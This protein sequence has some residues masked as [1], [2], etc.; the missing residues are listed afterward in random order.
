MEIR[1][2]ERT[3]EKVSGGVDRDAM[4]VAA[5]SVPAASSLPV[6]ELVPRSIGKKTYIIDQSDASIARNVRI[7]L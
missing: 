6:P 7:T 1:R 2:P 5:E 4:G 3:A